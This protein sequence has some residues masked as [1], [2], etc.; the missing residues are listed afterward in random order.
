[1]TRNSA[2]VNSFNA[3]ELSIRMLG[4]FDVDQYQRG[5]RT[6]K[7][8][9]VTP[10]G[11]AERRGGSRFLGRCKNDSG[12]V[13]LIPFV[14]SAAVAFLCEFGDHYIRFYRDD[15]PV[16]ELDSP[17]GAA[18][19]AALKF[20]QSNDVMFLV[21]GQR[22]IQ[23]LRRTG[24]NE[25][26]IGELELKYPPVREMNSSETT[27]TPGGVSGSVTLTAS[28]DLFK[29]GHIGSYWI[30]EQNRPGGT[31]TKKISDNTWT[32]AS[33]EMFGNWTFRTEGT[34]SGTLKLQRSS[35]LGV[36]WYD[37]L[38]YVIEEDNN[39]D[40]SGEETEQNI[41]YRLVMT[42]FT[43]GP[44]GAAL[45]ACVVTLKNVDNL[46]TGVVRITAVTSGTVAEGTV[47]RKLGSTLPTK[48]WGEGA[49]STLRGWP[50]AIGCFEERL[51]AA[52]TSDKS[53]TIWGSQT[54]DWNNFL[55]GDKDSDALEFT[56]SSDTVNHIQWIC[57]SS[58]LIVGTV[59]SEWSIS[60]P[61]YGEPLTPTTVGGAMRQSVYGSR[62]ISGRMAGD[63]VIFAQRGGR[64]LRAFLYSNDTQGFVSPDLTV[65]AEHIT[66]GNIVD[67]QLQQQPDTVIW[68]LLADGTVAALTYERD[69]MVTGW[70]RIVTDGSYLAIAIM[71]G[72]GD[73]EE[74]RIYCAVRRGDAVVIERMAF[75]VQ[76]GAAL[77][78][79]DSAVEYEGTDLLE[80]SGLGH[81]E[82]RTVQICADG[83]EE[84]EQ[85]V[86][87]G[88]VT[89]SSLAQHAVVGLGYESILEP[90]PI[91]AGAMRRKAVGEIR[92]YT[93]DSV[94]GEARCGEDEF[95]PMESR[96]LDCDA[97]DE[98]IAR[99]SG[100]HRLTVAGGYEAMP[101]IVVRQTRP[102]PLNVALM[103]I[104]FQVC[105]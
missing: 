73:E 68:C 50:R 10:Q 49:W 16:A 79:C 57:T 33:I 91:P 17:F 12:E 35:D 40:T 84:P 39:V 7:N 78:Y 85:T 101:R 22:M 77:C 30:L 6:L 105:E 14:R 100:I 18:E 2:I 104:G 103:E 88:C 97:M 69:Q 37:Y 95:Q 83:A 47:I 8:F 64:K 63:A 31:I 66:A 89:L 62:D 28:T 60:S 42:D 80:L 81:L 13:R 52:G 21:S 38:T 24:E 19:L 4:R 90:M 41:L 76:R 25:F 20:V 72:M 55:L 75:R 65:M 98:A 86:V 82:G 23:E 102:M 34:W 29:E 99:K 11:A 74:N 58:A 67:V 32:S 59:D 45:R 56:L 9:F 44:D 36:T 15:V 5:C 26:T 1:M 71:P 3:G 46:V 51:F 53:Q 48:D 54:G 61:N 27:L 92:I 94:G 43:H 93:Y 96:D 70:S 87:G